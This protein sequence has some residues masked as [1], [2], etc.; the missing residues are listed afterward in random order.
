MVYLTNLPAFYKIRLWNEIATKKS[1]LV[2]CNGLDDNYIRNKDF[3]AGDMSFDL[4]WLPNGGIKSVMALR[5]ILKD[6]DY[7][8]LIVTGNNSMTYWYAALS[9][10][11]RKLSAVCESSIYESTT[12]GIRGLAK[13]FFASR[14]H[15]YYLSGTAH[16]RLLD[17]LH[18]NGE[19][20]VT[21]G[22]GVFNYVP[23]PPFKSCSQDCN[24]LLYVGRLSPEKNLFRLIDV[25][26][27]HPGW[28]LTI[29]G[30]GPLEE[31]LKA[32]AK[33]NIKFTGAIEN[34]KLP[35]IYRDHDAFVLPSLS[36]VYG[37][38]VEEALNNGLPVALSYRVGCS[39]DWA[40]DGRYGLTFD[41]DS[42]SE[43]EKGL[44][45]ILTP[46]INNNM[47]RNIADLDFEAIERR[48][49]EFY[50]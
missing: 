34:K 5:N 29:V 41:P 32:V 25:V 43:I 17:A 2:I 8:E 13:R 46:E 31:E 50:L 11:R 14:F 10:P 48:Q 30:Y 38:V 45:R 15:K 44:L 24:R 39:D 21:H 19:M 47:R 27:R 9:N 36:D 42:E 7:N 6:L 20:V 23:Q 22:V 28:E 16:K 33:A 12:T 49:V 18:Y 4:V 3:T 26:N 35:E 40:L 37:L 1:L